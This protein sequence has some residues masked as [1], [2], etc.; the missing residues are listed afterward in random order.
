M[1][2]LGVL[3]EAGLVLYRKEGRKRL[4]YANAVPFREIYER[5][6]NPPASRAA[7]ADLHLKRYAEQAREVAEAMS[8][9]EFKRLKIESEIQ[10]N[11][12]RKQV[13]AAFTENYDD[14]WPHRYKPDSKC[15]VDARP[16]GFYYEHF[17]GGGGAITGTIVYIDPPFKLLSSGPSS[18]GRGMESFAVQTFEEVSEHVTVMKRSL[19]L[20]GAIDEA[21]E[22]MFTEGTRQFMEIALKGYLEEGTRFVPEVRP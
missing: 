17:A 14:W 7:E 1:Q 13:F 18:L 21:T 15:T 12:P 16:G 6:V 2:H 10:I 8:Q 9:T 19:E 4:N 11:A 3:E 22:K 5:W 20:W